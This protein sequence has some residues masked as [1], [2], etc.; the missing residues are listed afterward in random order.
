M[1]GGGAPRANAAQ[2]AA[3]SIKQLKGRRTTPGSRASPGPQSAP[4]NFG[5]SQPTQS[6]GAFQPPGGIQNGGGFNFSASAG[7][8]N[9]PFAASNGG[10]SMS[11][12][13]DRRDPGEEPFGKKG[14]HVNGGDGGSVPLFAS[15]MPQTFANPPS[16]Q[17]SNSGFGGFGQPNSM[18]GTQ[19]PAA[20][21]API[22]SGFGQ[23]QSSGP[24]FNATP[25]KAASF[26]FGTAPA[27]SPQPQSVSASFPFGQTQSQTP[28][29][30]KFQFGA[31]A[32]SS[33]TPASNLFGTPQATSTNLFASKPATPSLPANDLFAK[34]EA[35]PAP[36]TN[37]FGSTSQTPS[38]NL[39]GSAPAA[40]N[41]FG[42][43]DASPAPTPS[44][45]LFN[46]QPSS[47]NIFGSSVPAGNTL[48]GQQSSTPAQTSST[49]NLF[50]S[51]P[52]AAAT[53]FSAP[54]PAPNNLFGSRDPSPALS[55]NGSAQGAQSPKPAV[56]T[57]FGQQASDTPPK[58][59]PSTLF[60]N[61]TPSS[62]LF[63]TPNTQATP[64]FGNLGQANNGGGPSEK[65]P[66]QSN[67]TSTLF[68]STPKS[69]GTDLFGNL[70]K[71]VDKS[72]TEGAVEPKPLF[73]SQSPAP[74]ASPLFG[75]PPTPVASST[76]A[77]A[78]V[79]Y[80]SSMTFLA[81]NRLQST[82]LPSSTTPVAS[83][84]KP[85]FSFGVT[86]ATPPAAP[87]PAKVNLFSNSNAS[88]SSTA[89]FLSTSNA[90]NQDNGKQQ[91]KTPSS[92]KSHPVGSIGESVERIKNFKP[93]GQKTQDGTTF[94]DLPIPSQIPDQYIEEF[95]PREFTENQRH[96]FYWAFRIRALNMAMSKFFAEL[97][98]SGDP[99]EALRYYQEQRKNFISHIKSRQT[100][101]PYQ[102]TDPPPKTAAP[103]AT[104][105]Q[106]KRAPS[107]LRKATSPERSQAAPTSTEIQTNGASTAPRPTSS[108]FSSSVPSL[109]PPTS[110]SATPSS[111]SKRKA[112]DDLDQNNVDQHNKRPMRKIATP[113]VN[114]STSSPS[115]SST[116]SIFR[117]VLESPSQ[118]AE[119][120]PAKKTAALP[121]SPAVSGSETP[122]ANPFGSLFVPKSASKSATTASPASN[123]FSAPN[124]VGTPKA[125]GF[126]PTA[127]GLFGAKS[128]DA[129]VPSPAK[130][131]PAFSGFKPAAPTSNSSGS[132]GGFKM[133]GFTPGAT[134]NFASQF[135]KAAENAEEKKMK[136]DMENDMDSDEDP[137]EWKA[138]WRAKRKA[139]L[140]ELK[141]ASAAA[142]TAFVFKPS[143]DKSKESNGFANKT[144]ETPVEATQSSKSLFASST[145]AA[146]GLFGSASISRTNSPSPAPSSSSV[147]DS[148]SSGK[149]PAFGGNIFG[150]L[151]KSA[152]DS[153]KE[154]DADDE[155]EDDA[156]IDADSENKDP[157]YT[158]TRDNNSGPG[159]PADETGAGIASA[160]KSN[161]FNFSSSKSGSVFGGTS[162]TSTP[163]GL[164]GAAPSGTSTPGGSLFGR[165]TSKPPSPSSEEKENT[166]PAS[167][168]LF[169]GLNK[170]QNGPIDQTWKPD[171]PIKFGAAT[172]GSNDSKSATPIVN[173][174]SA[175]PTKTPT[176]SL[177]SNLNKSS[178]PTS[179]PF[180]SNL[181]GGPAASKA[182]APSVG[183]NF[184]G[185]SNTSSLFPSATT[186]RATTPG[187][188]TD[189]DSAAEDPDAEKH[190]QI[191]LTS[192]A[193]EEDEDI[194]FEVRAK[195]LQFL[196]KEDGSSGW[197]SKGLGLLKILQHKETKASRVLMRAE[198]RGNILLNK[199]ILG[200]F[201][202]E[203]TAKTVKLTTAGEAGKGLET[204]ILQ[205]KTPESAKELARTLEA[206]KA[207]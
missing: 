50:G 203:A 51:M 129:A 141:A 48:F 207:S 61:S 165:I 113:K 174:T 46:T 191:S 18:S 87:Q 110:N 30:P 96:E 125:T 160:K 28:S 72:V 71:P 97:Q 45:N 54:A 138:E 60:G 198:P 107:P 95:V 118:S 42:S 180:T 92:S 74:A 19:S 132:G 15:H 192:G 104:A 202:Y 130:D 116:A 68:S 94:G 145:P 93:D 37:L 171:S 177:F 146:S 81:A 44:T 139:K 84:S 158:P 59:V 90:S 16:A 111:K 109:P 121:G 183:F 14:R 136:E 155:S 89:G 3:R 181:F 157:N 140:D 115:N 80:P 73:G 7:G 167:T 194:Q 24:T 189:G 120:S 91:A 88:E 200:Q 195:A 33:S 69:S 9:N 40:T 190:E 197:E 99:A 47:S 101:N 135:G 148:Q 83:P 5:S 52:N 36:S 17:Q 156:D 58:T 78:F 193:G 20:T 182:A 23:T 122:K 143:V 11:D 164:F 187:A 43:R 25:Q 196:P 175:T 186:S 63:G 53:N 112:E 144:A 128:N 204:W 108:L 22:F 131:A 134:I 153:G 86:A 21:P 75:Q 126:A 26:T 4:L 31:T 55:A 137:E 77:P 100:T 179:A 29:Q 79:S 106:S 76:S 62:T 82:N 102:S 35:S 185:P 65:T 6:F 152:E 168:G 173:I 39:F 98:S 70:N 147:F 56:S 127:S 199:S 205:V 32:A 166:V 103:Q 10:A 114:G 41:P 170:S 2:L 1:D 123:L 13:E 119:K 151:S 27:A 66:A 12:N 85:V 67:G 149:P 142:S 64:L 159:T 206:N 117:D 162:G 34:K 178:T 188:T 161:L 163:G 124:P 57:L 172:L 184:G 8:F 49:Q 133:A 169:A 38:S 176:T 150:H 154:N 201:K 105:A